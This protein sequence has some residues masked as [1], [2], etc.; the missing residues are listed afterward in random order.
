MLLLAVQI[1]LEN[2]DFS[3]DMGVTARFPFQHLAAGS[4][5]T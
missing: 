3:G 4:H 5:Q 2:T 1:L